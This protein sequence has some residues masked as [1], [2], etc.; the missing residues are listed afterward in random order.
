MTRPARR[1]KVLNF[2]VS[3]IRARVVERTVEP[4]PRERVWVIDEDAA[5]AH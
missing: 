5:Q 3:Q 1:T 4:R 2:P